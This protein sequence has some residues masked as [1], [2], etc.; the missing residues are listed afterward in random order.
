MLLEYSP[1][2]E[3][4]H[5]GALGR[6]AA[7]F[8]FG[9][10]AA[11]EAALEAAL[12]DLRVK[13]KERG[14]QRR[15]RASGARRPEGRGGGEGRRDGRHREARPGR[16]GG[17]SG[18]RGGAGG[19]SPGGAEG[20]VAVHLSAG[21]RLLSQH[22][23]PLLLHRPRPLPHHQPDRSVDNPPAGQPFGHLL[24]RQLELRGQFRLQG[25]QP[26]AIRGI[27]CPGR[28]IASQSGLIRATVSGY[29]PRC[30]GVPRTSGTAN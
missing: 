24:A 2:C 15:F 23:R 19:C 17:G 26:E 12:V 11:A 27:W 20:T 13:G 8:F 1:C 30:G 18:R 14:S 5:Q 28:R 10:C 16:R 4:A 7:G 3:V 9:C 25:A 22:L 29:S 21:G 6:G